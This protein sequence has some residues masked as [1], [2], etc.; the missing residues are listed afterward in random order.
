MTRDRF[1]EIAAIGSPLY[2]GSGIFAARLRGAVERQRAVDGVLA[3]ASRLARRMLDAGLAAQRRARLRRQAL[4]DLR[5]L[6]DHL[7]ADLGLSRPQLDAVASGLMQRQCASAGAA[8]RLS[9]DRDSRCR[10]RGVVLRRC[11]AGARPCPA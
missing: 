1:G 6:D 4:R 7:L 3:G 5:A 9:A 10:R 8:V 11:G 2:P